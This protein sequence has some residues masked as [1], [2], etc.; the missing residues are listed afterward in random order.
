[1]TWM[2]LDHELQLRAI[3]DMNDYGSWAEDSGCYK[4]RRDIDD[5]NPKSSAQGSKWYE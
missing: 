5:M 3:V 2:T 4:Q 1:M